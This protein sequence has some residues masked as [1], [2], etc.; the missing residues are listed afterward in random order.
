MPA[1]QVEE[2]GGTMRAIAITSPGQLELREVPIPELGPDEV[3]VKVAAAGIC[4]S[5]L[6]ILEAAGEDWPFF[7]ITLG[8]ETAGH[9]QQVGSNVTD[10]REGDCVLLTLNWFC[11]HCRNCLR[12]KT[13]ACMVEGTRTTF[14]KTPGGHVDGGM[15]D[16]I[17][18]NAI[19]VDPVGDLDPVLVAPLSDAGTTPMHAINSA[20]AHLT[21]DATVAVIGVGG[22][23]H[24]G[25]QI[26]KAT[27][28]SRII[29]L[30]IDPAKL[31]I[32]RKYG[33]DIVLPSDA[34]AAEEILKATGGEGADVVIDFVGVSSTLTLARL[35]VAARGALRLVGLGGGSF[36]FTADIS[37]EV[38][39]WGV[40]V[41]RSN[42]GTHQDQREVIALA[43][44]GKLHVETVTYRLDDYQQAFD[45]LH[46]GR[47]PGRAVLVP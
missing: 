40:N 18:V 11:G 29:A 16:F 47:V 32:A 15:A 30:D 33:A 25:L 42:G 36:E 24:L 38:L 2:E 28:G 34:T 13:N 43:Q 6:A 7:G 44:Q 19:H 4:H 20:R 22:L 41:Q 45:D 31:D 9:V 26:L 37:G 46:H 10:L 17:K 21:P 8:H 5:D 1:T 14:T 35:V 12:G 27:T 3:L 23:G 39:P